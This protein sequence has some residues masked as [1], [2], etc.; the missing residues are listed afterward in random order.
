MLMD[1]FEK[2]Q[3]VGRND[4]CPCGS[5]KKFK[6]CH[7]GIS[8]QPA[9]ALPPLSKEALETKIEQIKALQKQREQQQG[10][11]KSIISLEFHGY[12]IVAV[13]NKLFYSK[14]WKTFHDFLHHYIKTV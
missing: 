5:E 3:K 12:R 4:P 1:G 14:G 10:L 8:A 13:G 11:G 9:P 6:K 2:R 7:G